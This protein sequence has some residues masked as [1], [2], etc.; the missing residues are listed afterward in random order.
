MKIILLKDVPQLAKKG[1]MKDVSDGYASN[2][3]IPKGFAVVA[4]GE[5]QQKLAKEHKE[6]EEKAARE[7]KKME[8]LK[9]DLEKRT[10]TL[11]VKVGDKGQVFGGIHEK[12]IAGAINEKMNLQFE[13]NQIELPQPIKALGPAVTIIKLSHH[14]SASIKLMIE[15]LSE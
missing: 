1:E 5:I 6:S 4:T 11:K 15:P 8:V 9:H 2:F 7:A 12:D 3:L 13:K 14:L 10:F